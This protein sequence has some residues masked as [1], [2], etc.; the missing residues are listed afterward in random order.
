MT[1]E[2]KHLLCFGPFEADLNAA[3]LR[4]G[5]TR[6][7]LQEQ[8]F[9][10]LTLLLLRPGEVVTREEI[11]KALWGEDTFVDFE[12]GLN[13]AVN[14]LRDSLVDSAENPRFIETLPKRGYRFIAPVEV[15]GVDTDKRRLVDSEPEPIQVP[16]ESTK[17][18]LRRKP[19]VWIFAAAIL[20]AR[21]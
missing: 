19:G 8:P 13:K 9:K 7:R 2:L 12:R 14:R 18:K 4:K 20:L 17:S 1:I 15:V 10:I 5:G 3:E 21:R 6:I 16:A 11:R